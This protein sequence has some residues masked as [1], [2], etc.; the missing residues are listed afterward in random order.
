MTETTTITINLPV[1]TYKALQQVAAQNHKT[2]SEVALEAI[3]VY[4]Q[5]LGGIDSLLGIFSN[6][7]ELIQSV[8][9]DVMNN[10]E[11]IS[12]CGLC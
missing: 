8:L 11:A 5:R 2:T 4:L 12:R 3:D 9:V 6:E 10:R 7:P 1:K